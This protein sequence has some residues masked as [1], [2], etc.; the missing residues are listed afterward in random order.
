VADGSS[1]ATV[2]ATLYSAR[3]N[4]LHER[5][6]ATIDEQLA[7]VSFVVSDYVVSALR[8]AYTRG[9]ADG[10]AQGVAAEAERNGT[11]AS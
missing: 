7:G 10:F 8:E 2:Y 6:R 11:A 3:T 1:S 4:E 5:V 9:V